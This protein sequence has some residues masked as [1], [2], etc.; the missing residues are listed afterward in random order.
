MAR[1]VRR[2]RPSTPRDCKST[3]PNESDDDELDELVTTPATSH[4]GANDS[5]HGS[6]KTQVPTVHAASPD[7]DPSGKDALIRVVRAGLDAEQL[8]IIEGVRHHLGDARGEL[9]QCY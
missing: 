6:D 4:N 2:P 7:E 5:D 9:S 8:K 3:T 1:D